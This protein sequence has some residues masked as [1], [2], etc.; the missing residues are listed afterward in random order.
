MVEKFY[1]Q[2]HIAGTQS[3]VSPALM[4]NLFSGIVECQKRDDRAINDADIELLLAEHFD[5]EPDQLSLVSW[6]RLH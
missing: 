3:L 4:S 5:I 2:F 1:T 6:C